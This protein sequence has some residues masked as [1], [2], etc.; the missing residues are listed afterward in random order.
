[1]LSSS[2]QHR[3]AVTQDL[4]NDCRQRDPREGI[5]GNSV[6][7]VSAVGGSNRNEMVSLR[8]SYNHIVQG[9]VLFR[10]GG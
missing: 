1:M 5:A 4:G 8:G 10:Q 2:D 3:Q 7:A 9:E 6:A